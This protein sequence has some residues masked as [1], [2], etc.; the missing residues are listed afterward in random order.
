MKK[1]YKNIRFFL[2]IAFLGLSQVTFAQN[3]PNTT[4]VGAKTP[5]TVPDGY[6]NGAKVNYVRSYVVFMPTS[7]ESA[8]T[9]GS[10]TN[11]QQ[12]TQ[13]V[14]A[15]GRPIQTVTKMG[16]PNQKDIV[17]LVTYDGF[18]RVSYQYMPY[19]AAT[20]TGLH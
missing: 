3:K 17:Q 18:G 10:V 9:S 1:L 16:T 4:T 15:L 13:Y 20:A 11:V 12:S 19:G 7:S 2:V 5:V 14:D 8:I 6:T